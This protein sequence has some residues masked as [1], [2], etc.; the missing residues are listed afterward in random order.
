[1]SGPARSTSISAASDA[2]ASST[3]PPL[4]DLPFGGSICLR[5]DRCRAEFQE[6]GMDSTTFAKWAGMRPEHVEQCLTTGRA[7]R[8]ALR[9]IRRG[10]RKAWSA[11]V[12]APADVKHWR[13]LTLEFLM[14]EGAA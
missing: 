10:I 4:N 8:A 3:S 5:S 13:R 7:S 6:L 11:K 12:G 1:M 9:R 2:N 14:A